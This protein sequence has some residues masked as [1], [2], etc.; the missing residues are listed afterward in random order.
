MWV[1]VGFNVY[2]SGVRE[3]WNKM[4]MWASERKAMGSLKDRLIFL[5][6]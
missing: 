3:E 2:G 4:I 5:E 6:E 1:T